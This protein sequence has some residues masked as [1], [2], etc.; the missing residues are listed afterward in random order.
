MSEKS[1]KSRS[2]FER[3]IDGQ[4]YQINW[5]EGYLRYACCDC[6]LVHSIEFEVEGDILFFRYDQEPRATGQLRRHCHGNLHA[7]IKNW[8][9]TRKPTT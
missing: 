6:G 7:G 2:K 3:M 9:L 5:K 4:A 1:L 8:Q